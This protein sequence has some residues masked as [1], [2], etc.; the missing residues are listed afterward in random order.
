MLLI[1]DENQSAPNLLINAY[2]KLEPIGHIALRN[3]PQR[4]FVFSLNISD[5]VVEAVIY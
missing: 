2:S 4:L 1:Q 3:T 5:V